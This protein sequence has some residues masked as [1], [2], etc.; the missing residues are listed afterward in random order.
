MVNAERLGEATAS[1]PPDALASRC[2]CRGAAH[3]LTI[4]GT[5]VV[6]HSE[7]WQSGPSAKSPLVG[8]SCIAENLTVPLDG[9][10]EAMRIRCGKAR[11]EQA[12]RSA[13][14]RDLA[15]ARCNRR[16]DRPR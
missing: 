7:P 16:R 1:S 11:G 8:V 2:F 3:W 10:A 15:G 9:K 6:S 12:L 13:V 14:R 5:E 4:S